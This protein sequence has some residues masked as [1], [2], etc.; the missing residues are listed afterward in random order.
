M[1]NNILKLAMEAIDE[2]PE[3]PDEMP[4]RMKETLDFAMS[5]GDMVLMEEMIRT[6]IRLTKGSI[7]ERLIRKVQEEV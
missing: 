2:E 5:I 7:L 6:T 3:Y 1:G 4:K